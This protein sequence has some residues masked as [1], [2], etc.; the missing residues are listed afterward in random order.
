MIEQRMQ[1][2]V[3]SVAS[4][5]GASAEMVYQ[6]MYAPTINTPFHAQQVVQVATELVGAENVVSD[7]TPSM[8]S[9]DFSFMLQH[10]PGAY[11]RL[12]QGGAEQGRLLH[13]PHYDFNDAVI[14]LGAAIFARLVETGMPIESNHIT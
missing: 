8:G 7:L 14:P 3:Q 11:F 9:E 4:A 1:T 6:K 5:F 2:M 13:S 10:R 12:G